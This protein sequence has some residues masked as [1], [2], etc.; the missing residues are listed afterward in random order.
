MRFVVLG[1][2]A[3][4][5]VVVSSLARAGCDVMAIARGAHLDAIRTRGLR[6]ESLE[7][8][9][10][11]RVAVADPMQLTWA[12]DDVLLLAVKTQDVAAAMRHIPVDVAVVCLANEIEAERLALRHVR[13][14]Y[15]ACVVVPAT[16][17]EPGVVQA[18]SRPVLGRIDIGRYPE[19]ISDTSEVIAAAFRA[20]GF[21]SS[22][23]ADIMRWKRGKLLWKPRQRGRGAVRTCGRYVQYRCTRPRRRR[24]L[25][26]CCGA[27][28]HDR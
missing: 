25:F 18:W 9:F 20:A 27:I 24:R 4:G 28:P 14:V 26:R 22:V 13:T 19:G 8:T 16:H 17:L 11:A 15:G 2:G 3:I 23:R 6:V 12:A 5:G 7:G 10:V 21:A 1:V